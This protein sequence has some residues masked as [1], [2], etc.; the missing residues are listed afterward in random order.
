MGIQPKK[1]KYTLDIR[2]VEEETLFNAPEGWLQT[3]IKYARSKIYGGVIRSLTLP[4]KFVFKG[5]FLLRREWYTSALMAKVNL[6]IYQLDPNTWKYYQ[7]YFGRLDFSKCTDENTGFTV[8]ATEK[9]INVQVDAFSDVEYQIPLTVS[10]A[11]RTAWKAKTGVYPDVDIL[12]TPIKLQET[13]DIIFSTSPDFRMN[14]FFQLAVAGNTQLSVNNSVANTGFLADPIAT[15]DFTND[16]NYFF[17]AR[18]DTNIRFNTARDPITGALLTGTILTSINGPSGGGTGQYQFNI[19]NQTGTLLKTMA[20]SPGVI[21]TTEFQFQFDFSL[22]VNAGDKLYFYII[23]ILDPTLEPGPGHGV[24]MQ[25]GTMTMTYYT[26]TPASHAQGLRASYVFDS[27]V[28]QMNGPENPKVTTQSFLLNGL[29]S[30]LAITCSN[31]ILTSQ[32]AT[33]Y[34]AGDN[35][36]IGNTYQVYG[37][38]STP[39]VVHYFNTA[40]AAVDFAGPIGSTAGQTFKAILDKPTFR[41]DPTTTDCYVQQISNNP[42]LIYSFNSFFKSIYGLMCGQAGV[43][44]DAGTGNYCLEDLRFFHRLGLKAL[45]LGKEIDI[46]WKREPNL[47]VACNSIKVGYNDEQY[48]ALNGSKEVCSFQEWTVPMVTPAKQV[49]FTSP[50][51]AAPYSIEQIRI[52]PGF[53]NPPAGTSANFYLN[54]AASKSDAKN[55]FVWLNALPD[56]GQTYYTPELV[57]GADTIAGVDPTYYNWKLSPK[58][59]LL[60]GSGYLSSI[61]DKMGGYQLV[62]TNAPKN[63]SLLTIV[64][65]VRIAESDPVQIADLGPQIFLPYKWSVPTGLAFNAQQLLQLNPFGEVAFTDERGNKWRTFMNAVSVDDGVN[66]PQTFEL[67]PVPGSDLSKLIF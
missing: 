32:L 36:Q 29:L 65:G 47:D 3:N 21:G 14:A 56:E 31:A 8:N 2:G 62:L 38:P 17:I 57:T 55:W 54:S 33:I 40:G 53:G 67:S 64:G 7:L 26:S 30:Q 45:D 43:G 24:N 58:Q 41:N 52:L 13:A 16:N 23:N 9:N 12:L 15:H 6:F 66:S 27:L 42:V 61:F 35:L 51:G 18:T 44:L 48:D 11:N 28:Q 4:M 20:Q 34:Q 10:S 1:F 5:A 25:G 59:C 63:S 19:Y 22:K 46:N 39:G 50:T 49:D 60:R 37:D